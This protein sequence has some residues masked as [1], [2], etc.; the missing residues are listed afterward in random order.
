MNAIDQLMAEH[1]LIVEVLDAL[2]GY[3]GNVES[4]VEV[5]SS[6]LA[7][8]ARFL[9]EF[10]DGCHHA[11]EE[12]IL[13]AAMEQAGFPREMGPLAVMLAEHEQG[14]G[15]IARLRAVAE[16]APS[17]SA[18]DR[19]EL[20]SAA[21]E[22]AALLRRH[23]AKEDGI[24]FPMAQARLDPA[25]MERVTADFERFER[26][27]TGPGEHEKLHALAERLTLRYAGRPGEHAAKH[28]HGHACCG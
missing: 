16:R 22:Y 20:A 28:A 7:E 15:Y 9:R 23:I 18:A 5:E 1:E 21:H 14:R 8:L 11:K 4:G 2:D 13:F 10:A 26:E 25:T 6:D 12:G 27:Q 19:A 3:A 17:W 24:L